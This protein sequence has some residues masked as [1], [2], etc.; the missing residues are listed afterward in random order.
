MKLLQTLHRWLGLAIATVVLLVSASGGLLLL[1]DPYYR[2]RFPSLAEPV[3]VTSV[4]GY[5]GVLSAIEAQFGDRQIRTVKFP[6]PGMNAFAVWFHDKS[7]GLIDPSTGALI[8]E[9]RWS[10][11][12]AAFLFELHAHLIGDETGSLVNGLTALAVVFLGLTGLIVW[13]PRRDGALRLRGAIPRTTR[14]GELLR[15]HAAIGALSV[16]P[17]M[18]FALTGAAIIFYDEAS[19]VVDAVFRSRPADEPDARVIPRDARTRPWPEV[20]A[21]LEATLPEAETVFLYPG[22]PANPRL[23]F[24]KRAPGEWHTNGRSYVVIDP[25]SAAVVQTIDARTQGTGTQV[26]HAVYPI[27]AAKVGG[28]GLV[29]LAALTAVVLSWLALGG[30]WS[31]VGSVLARRQR[32]TS[33]VAAPRG[34]YLKLPQSSI[35]EP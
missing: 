8:Y 34:P 7:Q 1:R 21:A 23:V 32:V 33:E 28:P 27:H 11:D 18:L 16:L 29:A 30:A 14:P 17:V 10:T 12:P 13:W 2:A 3:R 5:A 26:M 22:T 20:L 31:Y 19:A 15:S 6:R 25:Y 9:W 35:P 24:R 4:H